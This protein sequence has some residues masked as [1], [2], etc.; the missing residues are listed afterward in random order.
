MPKRGTPEKRLYDFI[1][2]LIRKI[3]PGQPSY[4]LT[5]SG[6]SYLDESAMPP[7]PE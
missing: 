5:I 4:R 6:A 2:L 3:N 7:F 1:L